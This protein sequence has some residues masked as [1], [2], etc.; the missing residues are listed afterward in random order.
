MASLQLNDLHRGGGR[1]RVHAKRSG[2]KVAWQSAAPVR[3]LL[4]RLW[5]PR[6]AAVRFGY[7][8]QSY[9]QNLDDGVRSDDHC[10]L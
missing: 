10:H 7:D 6:R 2:G 8:L 3:K 1:R 4:R 9:C 5:R